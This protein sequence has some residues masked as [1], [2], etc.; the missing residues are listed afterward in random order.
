MAK[1]KRANA[2]SRLRSTLAALALL[3]VA[4]PGFAQ[5]FPSVAPG[6]FQEPVRLTR[7]VDIVERKIGDAPTGPA[8]DGLF[9]EFG[10]MIV[11]SGWISAGPGYRK[12]IWS[13][14]AVF[15]TSAALSWRLNYMGQARIDVPGLARGRASVGAQLFY[16]DARQVNY[17]GLGND[18]PHALQS[19]FELRTV[20][21]TSYGQW[22]VGKLTAA[23]RA[24]HLGYVNVSGMSGRDPDY[25]DT[26]QLFTN[27]TAPGLS[28]QPPFLHADLSVLADTRDKIADPSRGGV[29]RASIARYLDRDSGHFT[30]NLYE[31]DASTYF[32]PI[33]GR[34][35][36]AGHAFAAMTS[37]AEGH[38]PP[39]YLMPNLGGSDTLRGYTD[40]R[41][42]DR[43][44]ELLS[45]EAR[46]RIYTH[47]DVAV[48]VD[49]GK[50]APRISDLGFT[51]LHTSVGFGVRLRNATTT[52]GRME[53]AKGSEGW[54]FVWKASEPF[55]RRTMSGGRT[56]VAPFVP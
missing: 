19:G 53:V 55:K 47:V 14:R 6:V 12:H 15:T 42:Y 16:Q 43:Q 8:S 24:G 35:V 28:A 49:S 48:F 44:M 50:V 18:S 45:L 52:F 26:E 31:L 33:P 10:N 11:G 3:C 22:R 54:R 29:Y 20:D 7:A 39:F 34:L 32:A 51:D 27:A 37:A 2:A 38:E 36:L 30:F 4:A 9:L 56:A 5:E 21:A 17:F 1:K 46:L 41:F 25:P 23:A 13:D 40:Y